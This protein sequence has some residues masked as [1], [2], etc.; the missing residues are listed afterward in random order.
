ML[1]KKA[2]G[3]KLPY[4]DMRG[5]WWIYVNIGADQVVVKHIK[6]EQSWTTKAG[7]GYKFTWEFNI[8]FNREIN[9]I[10]D[11]C[12]M[13]KEITFDDTATPEYRKSIIEIMKDFY[14][15]PTPVV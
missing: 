2:I 15:I 4:K 3:F 8:T 10:T 12:V 11:T 7:E 5:E 1:L 14:Q 13:I 6:R 9:Q